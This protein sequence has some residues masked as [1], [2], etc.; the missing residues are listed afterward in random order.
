[1]SAQKVYDEFSISKSIDIDKTGRILLPAQ[2]RKRLGVTPGSRVM[3]RCNNS[4]INISTAMH[5]LKELQ[6]LWDNEGSG[7]LV[8]E[9]NKMRREDAAKE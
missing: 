3:V 4:G 1:M 7:S 8:D 9:L 6:E 2:M 5:G